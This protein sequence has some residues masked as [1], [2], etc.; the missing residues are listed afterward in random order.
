L[1]EAY[2]NRSRFARNINVYAGKEHQIIL[3]NRGYCVVTYTT[4]EECQNLYFSEGISAK[5]QLVGNK[6]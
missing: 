4:S 2:E 5:M 6:E 3:R 1:K